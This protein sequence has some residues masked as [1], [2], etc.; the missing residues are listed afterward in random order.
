LQIC[1]VRTVAADSQWLSPAHGRD[2]VALH[3]TWVRNETA[4]LP[5]VRRLEEVLAPFGPRPHWGKV[6][7][8]PSTVVRGLYARLPDFRALTRSLDPAGTFTNAF[9]REL[10]DE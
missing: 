7:E 10:L 4:V 2:S 3:F 6:Y 1:E 8:M 9:V 5:V